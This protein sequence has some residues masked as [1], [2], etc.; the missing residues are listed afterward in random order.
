MKTYIMKQ[1]VIIKPKP[2]K[3]VKDRKNRKSIFDIMLEFYMGKMDESEVKNEIR[4]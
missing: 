2:L 3:T 4:R 1:I